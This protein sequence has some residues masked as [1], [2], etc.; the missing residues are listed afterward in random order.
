MGAVFV[1]H[2][3][4]ETQDF[5]A[6]FAPDIRPGDFIALRGDLGAGK[7]VFA[8]A[9]IR[10]LAG[11]PDLPVPSP[12]YTLVQSYDTPAGT[13]WHFDL[14]RLEA[15]DAVIELGW[16]DALAGG[17]VIA[18]WPEQAEEFLPARRRDLVFAILPD[19]ARRVSFS[20]QAAL[21]ASL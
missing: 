4:A 21:P 3:E 7:S 12:T 15:P 14:Y 16:D 20:E 10:A 8:R 1:L 13:V 2:G 17:I 6:S 9:L 19:G 18:E 5:A 11:D